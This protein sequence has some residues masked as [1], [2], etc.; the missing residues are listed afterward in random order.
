MAKPA[1]NKTLLK[2]PAKKAA[3]TD[4]SASISKPLD[5]ILD[6]IM[7]DAGMFDQEVTY[8]PVATGIN[9]L[10]Y[11]N[12]RYFAD[13]ETDPVNPP[14]ILFTGVPRG[15]QIGFVGYTGAGK[16]TLG[17]QV[18]M[19]MVIP[20]E[21]ATLYH[22]DL[23]NAWSDERTADIVGLPMDVVRRKY[24]RTKP[25][26]VEK[27]YEFI[28]LVINAKRKA[29]IENPD[30][31]VEDVETGQLIL[32][33]TVVVIDTVA[34]LQMDKIMDENVS[35]GS[36]LAEGGEQA[37]FNNLLA[38]RTAG[39]IGEANVT[40]I[41]MNHIR[42]KLTTGTPKAKRIQ[43]MGAEE[44]LPGGHGFPQMA[45]YFLKMVASEILRPDE[46]FKIR[47]KAVRC[48]I[49]KSRLSFDGRQ[50]ELILTEN[51]FS[52]A[53]S[54]L[55]FLQTEKAIS[56]AGQGQFFTHPTDGTVSRKF[57]LSKFASLYEEGSSS[58][59]A[60]FR[61]IVDAVLEVKLLDLIPMLGS[62]QEA[63]V[64][65]EG[66]AIAASE[67]AAAVESMLA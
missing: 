53:W 56:G 35:I 6:G 13:W 24:R 54:N 50:F 40:M 63:E 38:Q 36:A 31:L 3:V 16:T 25:M 28:K 33:P 39:I 12:G 61:R 9:V 44:S 45:D 10:D 22:V 59:D 32:P 62:S 11:F 15:K 20:Y 51:G 18:G 14:P 19:A 7:G 29:A 5:E 65:A 37:K 17:I 34:A 26:S 48:T 8:K 21:G 58:H 2:K 1:P 27:L 30:C 43:H 66:S 52:N 4:G 23:E 47:G 64:I 60:E 42:D 67:E 46:G 49:I 41:W 57:T 55:R